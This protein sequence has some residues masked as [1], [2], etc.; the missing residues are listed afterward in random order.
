MINDDEEDYLLDF[1]IEAIRNA[2][3]NTFDFDNK[4]FMDFEANSH[5]TKK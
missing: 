4:W 1:L 5:V 3:F 2:Y